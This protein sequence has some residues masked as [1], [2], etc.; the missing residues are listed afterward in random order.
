M[1]II[2]QFL[3]TFFMDAAIPFTN[4]SQ[5]TLV[6]GESLVGPIESVRKSLGLQ[7]SDLHKTNPHEHSYICKSLR[8]LNIISRNVCFLNLFNVGK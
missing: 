7:W 8:F 4:V 2:S 6:N 5:K 1:L 3:K